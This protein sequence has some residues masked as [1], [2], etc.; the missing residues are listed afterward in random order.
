MPK[1]YFF[2]FFTFPELSYTELLAVL[3]SFGFSKDVVTRFGSSIFLVKDEKIDDTFVKNIFDRLGG[4]VRVGEIVEDIDNFYTTTNQ[5]G[6]DSQEGSKKVIFG[7][8]ILGNSHKD[9][10]RFLKKLANSIKKGLKEYGISS[11]FVLPQGRDSSLNAAQ[12]IRN[13]ILQKGF[14]LNILRQ[15]SEEIYG[16]TIKI[17][18][19][20]GFV[21][22]DMNKP[23]TDTEMG[24]LPPKLARMMVNFTAQNSGTLWDP[25][26]GSG[27]I[28]MEAAMLGFNFLA[29]DINPQAVNDTDA[30]VRWLSSE[31]YISDTLYET[32]RFDITKPDM[33]IVK[34]L[35]HTDITSIVCEPYMGPP[36]TRIISE[37][38]ANELLEGVKKLYFKLFV[39]FYNKMEK[40]G[41]KV[42]I[43]IPS[44]KT[45]RGWKTFGIRELVDKRW[46][47]KNSEYS[48]EDLKW[49]RKNSIITRNIYILE[50]S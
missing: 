5:E 16:R 14:E 42:V 36:L 12:V 46:I 43:I 25:F 34:K 32:F 33:E 3:E 29:S 28:P 40:R 49:S 37:Q 9:D 1:Q 45:D 50:R 47:V 8:S 35:K 7:I 19:L 41:I 15:G 27:T 18:D 20:E 24:T 10:S 2:F 11:R 21:R 30:N 48:K 26:C 6:I 23:E 31:G 4:S 17:Q 44:Y 39:L 13:Q 22:R 38:K